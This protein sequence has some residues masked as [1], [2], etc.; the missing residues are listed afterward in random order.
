MQTIPQ[1]PLAGLSHGVKERDINNLPKVTYTRGN[2]LSGS[3]QRAG[4]IGGLLARTDNGQWIGG[5]PTAHAYYYYDGNGNVAGLVNTNGAIVA[6]YTYD[7]FGNILTMSGPLASA[8]TYRFSSKEWNN[9][10]GLYYYLYRFYDPNLQR[11]LNRDPIQEL[12]GLN[13]YNYAANTPLNL[14]DLLGYCDLNAYLAAQQAQQAALAAALNAPDKGGITDL[15]PDFVAAAT[16]L[17]PVSAATDLGVGLTENATAGAL[18]YAN[19]GATRYGN[20][21]DANPWSN[22]LIKGGGLYAANH[23]LGV[24]DPNPPQL[25]NNPKELDEQLVSSALDALTGLSES[26]GKGQNSTSQP[27]DSLAPYSGDNQNLVQNATS[28]NLTF[29]SSQ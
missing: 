9:N 2:D 7:P 12:G 1:K 22:A 29:C 26:L 13:L 3:L 20:W 25:P 18:D 8:N 6:Q 23:Y 24:E 4:G 28:P 19:Y 15:S 21:A 27:S 5:S 14:V 16:L 17:T 10:A 11:W